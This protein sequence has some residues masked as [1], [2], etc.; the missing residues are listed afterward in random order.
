MGWLF[1]RYFPMSGF[2]SD[3]P[4]IEDSNRLALMANL[5]IDCKGISPSLLTRDSLFSGKLVIQ[6]ERSGYRFSID[7]VLLAGMAGV[8][9]RDRV[10]ELGSGCGVVLLVL[11]FRGLGDSLVGIEIQRDLVALARGNA[12]ENGLTERVRF[13]EG[14]FRSIWESL[15][16]QSCDVVISNPPYRRLRSGRV[17]P[18]RQRAV[19]RHELTSSLADVFGAARHLLSD[20]GRVGLIYPAS[21]LGNLLVMAHNAGF[22]AKEMTFIHSEPGAP[23][24]LV[25]A[26]CSKRGGEELHISPPFFIYD[27]KGAY[28]EAMRRLYEA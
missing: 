19:A 10:V 4:G 13:L 6:Q 23:A 3:L 15:P 27:G 26:Q 14:D 8:R 22:R 5:E 2:R 16:P 7:S 20:A 25:F 28:S 12:E 1:S 21:R 24:R 17:N 9:P 18:N 11:A